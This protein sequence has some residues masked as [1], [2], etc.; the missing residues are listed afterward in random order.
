MK[1][2][3]LP[4]PLPFHVIPVNRQ[5][6]PVSFRDNDHS[7]SDATKARW[8]R[9]YALITPDPHPAAHVIQIALIAQQTA[10][11]LK[12]ARTAVKHALSALPVVNT[13][14]AAAGS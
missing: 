2:K 10:L 14:T 6:V 3:C 11:K 4:P 7:S 1:Q 5:V 13:R 12:Y 9:V 8:C